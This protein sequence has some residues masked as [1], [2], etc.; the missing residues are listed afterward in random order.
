MSP[1]SV[2][3][4]IGALA[5]PIFIFIIAPITKLPARLPRGR[6]DAP[7][8]VTM[9]ADV[10]ADPSVLEEQGTP[11]RQRERIK[12]NRE[13]LHLAGAFVYG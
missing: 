8:R 4:Q 6:S 12:K 11:R 7:D 5:A 9:S 1:G 3:G 13:P 10:Q 2:A